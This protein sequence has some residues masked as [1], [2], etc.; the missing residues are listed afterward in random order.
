MS[1]PKDKI[2]LGKHSYIHSLSETGDLKK[3]IVVGNYCSINSI[4]HIGWASYGHHVGNITT[5]PFGYHAPHLTNLKLFQEITE[6]KID[7]M[8]KTTYIGNDVWIGSDVSIKAG[9]IIGDGCIIGFNS[10]VTKDIPP[11]SIVGG[12]PA[13]LIRKRFDSEIIRKLLIIKWWNWTDTKI[14]ENKYFFLTKSINDFIDNFYQ[15]LG[16]TSIIGPLSPLLGEPD[17]L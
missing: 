14:S 17:A 16:P 5:Y 6:K 15:V 7:K 4:N 1:Y 2:K 8:K 10:N 12:N 3:H 11:Y 13:K 9:V